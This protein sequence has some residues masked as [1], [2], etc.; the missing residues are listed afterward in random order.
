MASLFGFKRILSVDRSSRLE[1][2][3]KKSVL[4]NFAKF[5]GKHLYGSL[6]FDEAAA[7][8]PVTL[9]EKKIQKICFPVNFAKFLK[10]IFFR[11]PL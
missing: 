10:N 3:C 1:V 5:T 8:K 6:F 9:S 7:C 2:F 4:K 11:E